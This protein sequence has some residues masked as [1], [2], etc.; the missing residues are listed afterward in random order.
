[1]RTAVALIVSLF[2]A[3]VSAG[4]VGPSQDRANL[5]LHRPATA[6]S[7]ENDEHAAGM[8]N[9]GDPQTCW[10]ADDEPEGQPDWWKVDLG[11]P[12]DLAECRIRWP[13]DGKRYR[14][15]LEASADG[16]NWSLLSDQTASTSTSQVHRLK[17]EHAVGVRYVKITVTAVDEGVGVGIAEVKVFGQYASNGAK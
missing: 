7:V 4:P 15:K 6:S 14:Y 17:L 16:K 11:R 10:I 12:A 5:A 1:M 8:A 3:W 13:Y 2:A 9:D